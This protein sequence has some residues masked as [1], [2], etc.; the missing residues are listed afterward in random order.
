M[1]QQTRDENTVDKPYNSTMDK[2]T[3]GS[4]RIHIF[5]ILNVSHEHSLE[6]ESKNLLVQVE[7]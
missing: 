1:R 2:S 3:Q 7:A 6:L 4:H 5:I